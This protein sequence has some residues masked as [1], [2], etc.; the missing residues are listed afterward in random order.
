MAKNGLKKTSGTLLSAIQAQLDDDDVTEITYKINKKKGIMTVHG[1]KNNEA[2]RAT[3]QIYGENGALQSA[4]H[5]NADM[6]KSER[7][8]VAKDLRKK[9]YKQ[10]EIA[11]TLQISQSQVSNLLRS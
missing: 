9:G 2:F 1:K 11:D 7:K 4:S 8:K 5:F 10:Q 3:Q 6:D